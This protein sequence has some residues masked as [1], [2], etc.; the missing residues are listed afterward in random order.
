[1]LGAGDDE[2]AYKLTTADYQKAHPLEDFKK[3]MDR[4]RSDVSVRMRMQVLL[5]PQPRDGQPRRA[6]AVSPRLTA[7]TDRRQVSFVVSLAHGDGRWQVSGAGLRDA[8]RG[9]SVL[10]EFT[11]ANPG[12]RMIGLAGAGTATMLQMRVTK[13]DD[14]SVTLEPTGKKDDRGQP[15]AARTLAIDENTKVL[16]AVALRESKGAAGQTTRSYRSVPGKLA[17]LKVGQDVMVNATPSQDRAVS[18]TIYPAQLEP[19]PGL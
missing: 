13:V 6:V 10:S 15:A 5:A 7:R 12:A 4:V 3:E 8:Q 2:G 9:N 19:G 11:R 14:K 16:L 18:I 17:D 1:V